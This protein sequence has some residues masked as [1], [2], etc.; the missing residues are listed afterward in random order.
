[1]ITVEVSFYLQ[2]TTL[3]Y[4]ILTLSDITLQY[5]FLRKNISLKLYDRVSNKKIYVKTSFW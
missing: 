2:Y 1:M 5:K 4:V 3:I